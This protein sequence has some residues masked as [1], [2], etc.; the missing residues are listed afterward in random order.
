LVVDSHQHYWDPDRFEYPWM[1]PRIGTL[2]RPFFPEHLKPLLATAGVDHT[3]IVQAISSWDEAHWLLDLASANDFIV[4]VVTW[5][6]LTS[7]RLGHELDQ[8]QKAP[9]FKG[10]R[11]QIEDETADDWMVRREVL[12][13][14]RELEARGLPYDMLVRPRHLKFLPAVREY[15]P[16]LKLVIDHLAKP[17]IATREFDLWAREIEQMA[18]LPG[19][20]CKLSGMNTEADWNNWT[21]EDFRPYVRHVLKN[22][23]YDRVMFGSDWPVCT[24]A[25]TYK[26]T[27]DALRHVL[28]ELDEDSTM[29]WGTNASVFYGLAESVSLQSE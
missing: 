21:P 4:G 28:G 13:G 11:H 18:A 16:R 29:V 6:D 10:V 7:S 17:A 12:R 24:L 2:V 15:C 14:F 27:V 3:I 9:K 19:I 8:L 22:F 5:A 23:G 25:G 20:W 26:Q 1:N